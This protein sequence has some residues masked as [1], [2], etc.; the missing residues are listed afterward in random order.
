MRERPDRS[1]NLYIYN[2]FSTHQLGL[3]TSIYM[4]PDEQQFKLSRNTSNIYK[5]LCR[6]LHNL[7]K[8]PKI[9]SPQSHSLLNTDNRSFIC[10]SKMDE[11]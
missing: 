3:G 6:E 8:L 1:K 2:D 9:C 10:S 5:I 4:I 7:Y 11:A